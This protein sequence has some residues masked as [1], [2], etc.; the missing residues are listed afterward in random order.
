MKSEL[1]AVYSEGQL[2]FSAPT[3]WPKHQASNTSLGAELLNVV[4]SLHIFYLSLPY[5]L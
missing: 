1:E 2:K 3:Q 5:S 4:S